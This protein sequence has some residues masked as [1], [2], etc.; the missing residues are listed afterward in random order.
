MFLKWFQCVFSFRFSNNR[1]EKIYIYRIQRFIFISLSLNETQKLEIKVNSKVQLLYCNI[2]YD[3]YNMYT[4]TA[5]YSYIHYN[6]CFRMSGR[7]RNPMY[8]GQMANVVCMFVQIILNNCKR[9]L[10]VIKRS[11]STV[12]KF[13]NSYFRYLLMFFFQII[14]RKRFYIGFFENNRVNKTKFSDLS[15]ESYP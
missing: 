7:G 14:L 15:T 8:R 4:K 12:R 5:F 1:M 2:Y 9:R 6:L 13:K 3:E 11:Y 10:P